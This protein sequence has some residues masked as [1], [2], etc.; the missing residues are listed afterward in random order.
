MLGRCGALLMLFL[1]SRVRR[2]LTESKEGEGMLE[3][4]KAEL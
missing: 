4:E 1:L 3:T 2:S